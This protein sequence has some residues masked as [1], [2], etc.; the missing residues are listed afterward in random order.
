[1]KRKVKDAY[2]CKHV[3]ASAICGLITYSAKGY[4]HGFTLH[5]CLAYTST[6]KAVKDHSSLAIEPLYMELES[7]SPYCIPN[8]I[9][10]A[11][12]CVS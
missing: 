1:M 4:V 11:D 10:Q 8:Y 3:H 7:T 9:N 6:N 2:F 12:N 5:T